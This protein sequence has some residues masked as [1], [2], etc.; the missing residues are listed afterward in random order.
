MSE[1]CVKKLSVHGVLSRMLVWCVVDDLMS[2][3]LTSLSWSVILT[4]MIASF[5]MMSTREIGER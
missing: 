5:F 4:T 2:K 3:L 1:S